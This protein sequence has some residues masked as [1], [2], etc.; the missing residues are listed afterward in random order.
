MK[1]D[2]I[3]IGD[4]TYIDPSY[5]DGTYG[6]GLISRDF[7]S[8]PVGAFAP[9]VKIELVDLT[10]LPDRI[11]KAEANKS[12]LSDVWKAMGYRYLNQAQSN[13]CW[14]HSTTHIVM[15]NRLRMSLPPAAL[16]A[17][18][19]GS[20][21]KNGRNDGGWSALSL[22]KASKDGICLQSDWPQGDFRVRSAS[23]V[24]WERAAAFK[25]V[26]GFVELDAPV[27]DRD[28]SF[29]QVLTLLINRIP[30]AG[31]FDWWGHAVALF[32]PVDKYPNRDPKDLSRYAVRILNSWLNFGD[33]GF[34]VLADGRARPDNAVS[35]SAVLAA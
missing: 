18:S 13:Y 19:L 27:F 29:H 24:C 32:D 21:I 15:A 14:A 30:V 3:V 34:A 12:R 11:R 6:R 10:T 35:V 26:D 17:Y 8:H 7:K 25:P 5:M 33:E 9:P 28:L 4:D 1:S 22:D 31:D 23:D 20:S 2:E 16:S